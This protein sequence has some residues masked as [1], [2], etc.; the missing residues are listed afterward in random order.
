MGGGEIH[1]N[2]HCITNLLALSGVYLPLAQGTERAGML[3][4]SPAL[5]SCPCFSPR[6]F[7]QLFQIFFGLSLSSGISAFH[8]RASHLFLI[9]N[10]MTKTNQTFSC[11]NKYLIQR[12]SE[13]WAKKFHFLL[14][15]L[16]QTAVEGSAFFFFFNFY[17]KQWCSSLW[18]GAFGFLNL[19]ES[20]K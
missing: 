1:P 6:T 15:W 11:C 19:E 14:N 5:W 13:D 3:E 17:Y 9:S 18:V 16:I 2:Q 7:V 20:T 4:P 10:L 8:P 12:L